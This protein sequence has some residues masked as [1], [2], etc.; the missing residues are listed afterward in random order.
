MGSVITSHLLSLHHA[1]I[2]NGIT[3]LK[4]QFHCKASSRRIKLPYWLTPCHCLIG[5]LKRQTLFGVKWFQNC[6]VQ[7]RIFSFCSANVTLRNGVE[8]SC[9]ISAY[10]KSCEYSTA[11]DIQ[12]ITS[13]KQR[14]QILVKTNFE[15]INWKCS[16]GESWRY[17]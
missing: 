6:C 7:R 13:K 4:T 5:E 15:N 17:Q 10:L 12:I 8:Q 3:L 2:I 1:M 16:Q 9:C 11:M 14:S